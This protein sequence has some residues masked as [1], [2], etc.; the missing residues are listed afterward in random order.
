MKRLLYI[1]LLSLLVLPLISSCSREDD[2][3]FAGKAWYITGL[4]QGGINKNLL[5]QGENGKP[6]TSLSQAW[7]KDVLAKG[8]DYYC[9]R[10]GDNHTFTLQT[11]RRTWQGTVSYDLSSRK[12]TFSLPSAS[13]STELENKV[14]EYMKS[15][16]SY[17]GNTSFM[18]FNCKTGDFILLYPT[19]GSSTS[20]SQK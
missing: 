16:V 3:F 10:F 20:T 1:T 19:R 18:H 12:L 4:C 13:T 11:E 14:L 7:Q 6:N 9:I 8:G 15:V 5:M 2:D 17:S